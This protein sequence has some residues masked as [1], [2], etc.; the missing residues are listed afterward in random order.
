VP[1]LNE[2]DWEIRFYGQ[3][4]NPSYGI[5]IGWFKLQEINILELKEF[6]NTDV[7]YVY[8]PE[9]E[10]PDEYKDGDGVIPPSLEYK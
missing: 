5:N 9:E 2:S 8:T 1:N 6:Q 4:T 10:L 3:Y 7:E